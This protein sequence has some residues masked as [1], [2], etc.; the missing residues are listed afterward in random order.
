MGVEVAI[1]PVLAGPGVRDG[2]QVLAAAG[3]S[4]TPPRPPPAAS[5]GR[6]GAACRRRRLTASSARLIA[7]NSMWQMAWI[8]ARTGGGGVGE[9]CDT[10]GGTERMPGRSGNVACG[11]SNSFA[12][13]S[14]SYR[15]RVQRQGRA[16][17]CSMSA[18]Q[19][20]ASACARRSS[21][22]MTLRSGFQC[23]HPTIPGMSIYH[24]DDLSPGSTRTPHVA[25][26]AQGD[27]R[28]QPAEDSSVWYGTVIR[29]DS[30]TASASARAATSRRQRAASPTRASR[31]S[32]RQRVT[33]G[34][35][36]MLHGCTIGDES[37]IGIGAVLLNGARI[38]RNCLVG[39]G[40][41]VTEGKEFPDGSMIWAAGQR[42]CASSAPSRS[43]FTVAAPP[44]TSQRPPPPRRVERKL[45]GGRPDCLNCTNSCSKARRCAA[46]WC[47]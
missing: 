23:V 18:S 40:S 33:V 38:G 25:D 47:A 39:A 4:D 1:V 24:P 20:A 7:L 16:C 36:V 44:T 34:H 17:A 3:R 46:C 10:F 5:R 6:T 30:A 9:R 15:Q 35:Q 31:F 22:V 41:L 14:G 13:S 28:S 37:L 27:R 21:P 8:M 2:L 12:V 32:R 42:W 29:G 19:S 45:P 43:G 11:G 26:S